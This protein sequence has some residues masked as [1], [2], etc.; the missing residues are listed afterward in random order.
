VLPSFADDFASRQIVLQQSTNILENLCLVEVSQSSKFD[1]VV[2]DFLSLGQKFK[3][4]LSKETG[5]RLLDMCE[6]DGFFQRRITLERGQPVLTLQY[7]SFIR[8][9]AFRRL[10]T[11]ARRR[12]KS[13]LEGSLS[14][15]SEILKR[16]L[17]PIR[18][19]LGNEE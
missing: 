11:G 3:L 12:A 8:K 5:Q 9:Y 10:Y 6:K 2:L 4:R 15:N 7:H 13:N 16:D 19:G 14:F 18:Q 17:S 1:Y